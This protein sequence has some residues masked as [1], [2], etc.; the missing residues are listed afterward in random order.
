MAMGRRQ[1]SGILRS[2]IIL[3][4]SAR[5]QSAIRSPQR[6]LNALPM[7][8]NMTSHSAKSS[9]TCPTIEGTRC[10]SKHPSSVC[11]VRATAPQT[12]MLPPSKRT[13]RKSLTGG[14]NWQPDVYIPPNGNCLRLI[15]LSN[16]RIY[17]S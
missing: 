2:R 7:M 5:P 10:R 8:V 6:S 15:H 13:K 4:P 12:S 17:L 3:F 11:P 16:Y 14:D 9:M 1:A